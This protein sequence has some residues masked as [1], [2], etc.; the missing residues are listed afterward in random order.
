MS[1]T[2]AG[3]DFRPYAERM[4]AEL[5]SARDALSRQGEATGRLRLAAPISFGNSHLAPVLAELA[6]RHPRLEISA[7]YSDR[8]VDLVGEGFDAAVRLGNL[9][10][11][12]PDRP[13]DRAGPGGDGG[14]PGVPRA[15]GARRARRRTSRS[16]TRSRMA[17]RS[18]SSA[19]DGKRFTHRPRGRFTADSGPAELAGVV[20]GLGIAVMPAFLAGPAIERGEIVTLLEDYEIPEAGLYIVRPPPAEP[21]PMKIKALTDIMV[22]KFGSDDWD[23]CSAVDERA[24]GR[25][26]V[27]GR[28]VG[29]AGDVLGAVGVDHQDVVL[30]VAAGAGGAERH[31]QHRLHRD[32]HA[33][34]EH[35]VDVLAELEAGLA[36]V[37]V[38]QDAEGV[39]VAEAA[40]PEE[41]A[42]GEEGVDRGDDVGAAG[43]GADQR[44]GRARGR[45]RWP[46][47]ARGEAGSGSPRKRVRSSAV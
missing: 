42:L 6:V 28:A 29:E 40:V 25:D 46:P 22:E 16:T 7:S 9:A 2:E 14:E 15:G 5:Q 21:M 17:T 36:A 38:R 1:L 23:G 31:G 20:A 13:T 12:E 37:V 10:D 41:V 24:S 45:R 27:V 18:G 3:S 39:A 30:A 34:L 33:G 4:V 47:R 32:H 8:L 19:R 35:G 26:D 44:R 11:F 43:A